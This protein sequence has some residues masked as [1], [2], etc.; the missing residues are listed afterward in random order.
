MRKYYEAYDDRYRQV[1]GE[2]LQWFDDASSPIVLQTMQKYGV[3]TQ[4]AVLELGCGEGRDAFALLEAGYDLLATDISNEAVRWCRSRRP[5]HAEHFRVLDCVSGTL[6]RHYDFIYAVAVLHMLVPDGDRNAFY[7]FLRT[8]LAENGLALVCTMGDGETECQSDIQT[9][10]SLQA[11]THEQ[12][13]RQLQ[14]AG[15][16]CR[17]VSFS[18]LER[19]I[20][21]AGLCVRERGITTTVP[22]FSEM[23]YVVLSAEEA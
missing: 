10:F 2:K 11:R 9:A 15:T 12:S 5:E 17:M 6:E 14:I 1:H 19:E 18:T 20:R 23:M 3:S 16:S 4:S 8:H 22:G 13:G 21:Q 7:A